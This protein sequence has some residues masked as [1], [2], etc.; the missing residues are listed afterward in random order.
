MVFLSLLGV[1]ALV[2]WIWMLIDCM[3]REPPESM[4][5]LTWALVILLGSI[6]GALVYYVIRKLP[7]DRI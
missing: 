7:R 3:R 6:V 4:E 5:K 1:A 2:F